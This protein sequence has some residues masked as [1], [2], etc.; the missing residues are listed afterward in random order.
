MLLVTEEKL[1]LSFL[2]GKCHPAMPTVVEARC[3]KTLLVPQSKATLSTR[4]PSVFGANLYNQHLALSS[5][6]EDTV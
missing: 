2:S 5:D 3:D 1:T 6:S 4:Q